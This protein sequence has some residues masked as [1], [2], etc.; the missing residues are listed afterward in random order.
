[1]TITNA[2]NGKAPGRKQLSDQLDRLDGIID[3]LAEGLN[4]AVADACREGARAAVREVLM[5][6]LSSPDLMAAVSLPS[7]PATASANDKAPGPGSSFWSR[8][9][10]T[11]RSAGRAVAGAAHTL[12]K[13]V[14]GAVK[15]ATDALRMTST[16]RTVVAIAV[17][18]G[19]LAGLVS[20][21]C[22]AW[23]G[24]LLAAGGS[25]GA[26]GAAYVGAMID[27]ICAQLQT[28]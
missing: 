17:G 10:A 1:V 14:E 20:L 18:A 22:P 8:A 11:A 19:L 6:L 7:E 27:R 4:T 21:V 3:A 24:A 5:E 15:P 26:V 2:A 12:V 25:V 28:A 13:S 16:S 9:K 23:V